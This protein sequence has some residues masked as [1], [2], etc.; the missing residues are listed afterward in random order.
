MKTYSTY[1]QH[2]CLAIV[3]IAL[4]G[5]SC[6]KQDVDSPDFDVKLD[7]TTYAVGEPITF[8]FTGTADVV[9]FFSGQKGSE[10]QY[11][12]RITATGT[13]R[14]QFETWLQAGAST[15]TNTLSLLVSKDF[16]GNYDIENLQNASWTDITSR[17]TLST[18]DDNTPS[19]IIDLTDQ[20]EPNVPIYIAFRYTAAKDAAAAQPKWTVKNIAIDNV[21]KDGT[22]IPIA[23]QD[24][25]NWG[26]LSVL[27]SANIW[28]FNTTALTFTGGGV[29]A[30]AN[31]DWVI[32]QP[33]QLDRAPRDLGK[34]IKPSP[35][36][37]LVTYTFDGYNEPG[38]YI[39]TFEA[40][41]ASKW[42]EKKVVKQFT[43]TVQ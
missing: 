28:S 42:D 9:T 3:M 35:T 16:T 18:G 24:N 15:Q 8:E 4:I 7:S 20:M 22:T 6:R 39:A 2:Y 30:E 14:L 38:T 32:S 29:N 25:L 27:N 37:R 19:G 33:I 41:N 12:D 21:A 26:S 31:E 34:S 1:L 36:T 23:A 10:Y 40:I 13:P 11:K 17:A 43:I 5:A